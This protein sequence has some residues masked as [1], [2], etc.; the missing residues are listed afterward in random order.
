MTS[1][2][3]GRSR[4]SPWLLA[5]V[6]AGLLS[7]Q[8]RRPQ[9]VEAKQKQRIVQS[10]TGY[11]GVDPKQ[12]YRP[13]PLNRVEPRE[14]IFS[15]Y[16]RVMNP[17][18]I[19]WGDELNW[20]LAILSEQSA[21]NPYFRLCAFQLALIIMLLTVC[22][23][24]WDKLRQVKWVAAECLADAI[25]AKAA[26]ESR[27]IDAVAVHNRHLEACNRVVENQQSGA[28]SAGSLADLQH[29]LAALR[30]EN[31]QLK[32]QAEDRAEVRAQLEARL[33]GVEER[34]QRA[35]ESPNAELMARLARAEAQLA[36]RPKRTGE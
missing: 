6:I 15:F 1:L 34:Q 17:R 5:V 23:L 36:N 8:E 31:A 24:W 19:R 27:A 30:A 22:W 29:E 7:A 9:P 13:I 10:G 3:T 28:A 20:R 35:P 21:E 33:R 12:P 26:A 2:R 16:L 25:N 14:S 32:A 18:Q 11:V 4:F